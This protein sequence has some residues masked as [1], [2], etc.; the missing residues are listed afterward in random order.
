ML[1]KDD[2]AAKK[3]KAKVWVKPKPAPKATT[4]LF[5]ESKPRDDIEKKKE[6][7]DHDEEGDDKESEE[8][9]LLTLTTTEV[10]F[11][12]FLFQLAPIFILFFRVQTMK[13]RMAAAHLQEDDLAARRGRITWQSCGGCKGSSC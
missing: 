9:Y 8:P 3:P 2:K 5:L 7:A 11:Y 12:N 13:T 1:K 4:V 6:H 10:C